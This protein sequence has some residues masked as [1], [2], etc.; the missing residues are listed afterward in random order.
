MPI[1]IFNST[2]YGGMNYTVVNTFYFARYYGLFN[3]IG[4]YN[5]FLFLRDVLFIPYKCYLSTL[6]YLRYCK[7]ATKPSVSDTG[8][9]DVSKHEWQG[10]IITRMFTKET[11]CNA[12]FLNGIELNWNYILIFLNSATCFYLMVCYLANFS[13]QYIGHARIAPYK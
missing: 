2:D 8:M 12:K 3:T 10:N 5:I 11:D 13:K 4:F 7:T 6:S 1:V 9:L